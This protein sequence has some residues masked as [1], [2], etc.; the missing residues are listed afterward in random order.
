MDFVHTATVGHELVVGLA[1]YLEDVG[2]AP[3]EDDS[4]YVAVLGAGLTYGLGD[5]VQLDV[6]VNVGLTDSADD[7]GVFAG[8]T[9]RL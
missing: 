4:D 6:G 8:L 9:F 3:S 5:D 7:L 2:I 1:G